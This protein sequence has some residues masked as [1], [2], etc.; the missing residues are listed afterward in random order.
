MGAEVT[1]VCSA[2]NV[3]T[4][5]GLRRTRAASRFHDREDFTRNGK[6]YDVIIMDMR[7]AMR[8]SRA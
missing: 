4:V 8:H 6:T 7:T 3:E 5:R 1:G 2:T